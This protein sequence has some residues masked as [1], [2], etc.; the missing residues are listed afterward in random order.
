MDFRKLEYFVTVAD[1]GSITAAAGRLHMSQPPLST[2]LKLLEEELGVRLFERGS[3]S[4]RLTDAGKMLYQRAR[5]ILDMAAD[6]EREVKDFGDGL[7]GSLRLGVISSAGSGRFYAN[8][9]S[10]KARYPRVLFEIREGNTYALL[11]LLRQGQ[12]EAALL[13]TPFVTEGMKCRY[14]EREA[15]MAVGAREYFDGILLPGQAAEAGR[16]EAVRQEDR[17]EAVRHKL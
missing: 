1:E 13:R 11:E 17:E 12:I 5:G 9:R 3:R 4:I 7:Q 10:F 16:A 8:I 14:L 2:Q 15:M 6:A